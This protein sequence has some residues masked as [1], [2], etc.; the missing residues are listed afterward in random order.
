MCCHKIFYFIEGSDILGLT[1]IQ[2]GGFIIPVRRRINQ[3]L[4]VYSIE[5]R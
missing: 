1:S 2:Y 5:R 3:K 4:S